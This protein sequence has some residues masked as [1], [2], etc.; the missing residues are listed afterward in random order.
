VFGPTPVVEAIA[1]CDE[2]GTIVAASPAAVAWTFNALSVLHAMRGDFELGRR[3]V[4]DANAVLDELG[5]LPSIVSHHEAL[6][7]LLAGQYERAEA[8]LRAGVQRL[9]PLGEVGLLA[10]TKAMLAQAVYAQR[11]VEE[12]AALCDATAAITAPDDTVTRVIWRGV[13][14]KALARDGL[15]EEGEALAREAI[16]LVEP[17][18]LLSHH[19]DALL[20]L[21]EV[22]R[23]CSRADEGADAIRRAIALYERKGNAAA[24]DRARALLDRG[25]W[26]EE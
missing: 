5:G 9:E 4:D 8:T 21:A 7:G 23:M 13:K 14:A 24:A 15:C 18:D 17:T 2:F 3:Y 6:V 16:G 1:L 19:G 11:R 26:S 25:S 22:L 12:A 10:T 20:D